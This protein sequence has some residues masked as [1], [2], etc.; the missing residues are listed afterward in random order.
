MAGPPLH[1]LSPHTLRQLK[2]IIPGA[3]V[4]FFLNTH[5][6][7]L[8]LLSAPNASSGDWSR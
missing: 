8:G 3:A 4:T 6:I 7:L 1:A 5:R 2:F